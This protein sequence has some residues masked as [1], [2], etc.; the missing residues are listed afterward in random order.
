MTYRKRDGAHHLEPTRA[1]VL[2]Q[3]QSSRAV[4]ISATGCL[5]SRSLGVEPAARWSPMRSP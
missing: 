1:A 3:L 5:L 2:Q 4:A